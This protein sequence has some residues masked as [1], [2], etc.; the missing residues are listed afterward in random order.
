MTVKNTLVHRIEDWAQK[1]ADRPALYDKMSG[2]WK[3]H[4]WAE[5]WTAVRETAKGLIDLGV[6]PGDCVAI[7]GANRASDHD[8][9]P[10]V[11]A[12]WMARSIPNRETD[13]YTE[14]VYPKAP[15][16]ATWYRRRRHRLMER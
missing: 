1:R 2:S 3:S 15:S 12:N 7:V 6:K 16:A 5:Y 14:G 10:F 9:W 8:R 11:E 4:T 13:R